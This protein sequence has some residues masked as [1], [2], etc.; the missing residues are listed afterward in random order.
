MRSILAAACA[1]LLIIASC[2][3]QEKQPLQIHIDS[4]RL[5]HIDR[6]QVQ[7]EVLMSTIG[8]KGL[9]VERIALN[10]LRVNGTPVFADPVD[11]DVKTTGGTVAL[12][13]IHLHIYL[14]D[15]ENTA[16][17]ESLLREQ[18]A[19]MT[20]VVFVN[21]H[22]NLLQ[23]IFLGEAHPVAVWAIQKE[24]PLHISDGLASSG[25]DLLRMGLNMARPLAHAI[26]GSSSSGLAG[27]GDTARVRTCWTPSGAERRCTEHLVFMTGSRYVTAAQAVEPWR[28]D[29]ML[30]LLPPPDS[31]SV[32]VSLESGGE[33]IPVTATML[34]RPQFR[35]V[36]VMPQHKWVSYADPDAAV[37]FAE[38]HPK[39]P[40]D[41]VKA[42]ALKPFA[43][44][45]V[46]CGSSPWQEATVYHM[47]HEGR[48]V[49]AIALKVHFDN[50]ALRMS[51]P[52]DEAAVGSPIVVDNGVAG[53]VQSGNA[54][55]P[56]AVREDCRDR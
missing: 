2:H 9:H 20:A 26:F 37:A 12:P 56:I 55:A 17:L 41:T 5:E 40:G 50:G 51:R 24:V 21:V 44:N 8:P 18:R 47:M 49:S 52:L 14:A 36:L 16:W 43:S 53:V 3:A 11:M 28:F 39:S 25:V 32:E 45:A 34:G 6:E 31:T 10:N 4:V 22:A 19:S 33:T 35:R 42:P 30:G 54:A 48:G 7:A 15:I 29:P 23:R 1:V 27:A 13:P 38:L 46:A